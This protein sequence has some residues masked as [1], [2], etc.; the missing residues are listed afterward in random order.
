MAKKNENLEDRVASVFDAFKQLKA[1][2]ERTSVKATDIDNAAGLTQTQ[3][4]AAFYFIKHDKN[5]NRI[6]VKVGSN[7]NATW[8]LSKK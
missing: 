8:Y 7:R 2:S 1:T 4:E 6:L 3:R 5:E